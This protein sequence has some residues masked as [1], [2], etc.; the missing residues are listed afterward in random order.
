MNIISLQHDYLLV[1]LTRLSAPVKVIERL[2]P[3]LRIVEGIEGFLTE[4]PETMAAQLMTEEPV[5]ATIVDEEVPIAAMVDEEQLVGE[6][7]AEE[8]MDGVW[9]DCE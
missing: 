6:I 5:Q 8:P 9:E 3:D 7:V 1:S 4:E 2:V